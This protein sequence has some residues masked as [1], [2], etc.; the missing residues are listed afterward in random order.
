MKL[1]RLQRDGGTPLEHEFEVD[2]FDEQELENTAKN[3]TRAEKL[4]MIDESEKLLK[5]RSDIEALN[6]YLLKKQKWNITEVANFIK[7]CESSKENMR[8]IV[9]INFDLLCL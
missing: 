4:Q 9:S 7:K 5:D 3:I 1:K 8:K 2:G 6:Y